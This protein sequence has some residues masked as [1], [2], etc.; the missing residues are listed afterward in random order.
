MDALKMSQCMIFCRT[1]LDCDHLEQFLIARGGGKRF[2]GR[3]E[4]GTENVYSCC[5]LAGMRSM[6]ERRRN[7]Q[8]FKDGDVRF[9]ICTDVAARGLDIKSLPF[10]INLTLPDVAENYIHRSVCVRARVCERSLVN[11]IPPG[12]AA[13]AAPTASASPYPSWRW[14]RKRCLLACRLWCCPPHDALQ[15]WFHTCS[16]KGRDGSCSNTKLVDKGGCCI[17]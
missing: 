12:S 16:S 6:E 3:V 9:L 1:N 15:V 17:W 4:K 8:Y 10:V 7:L 13:W 2:A 11:Y 5:V 14:R